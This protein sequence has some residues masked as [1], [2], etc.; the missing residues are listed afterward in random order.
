MAKSKMQ[1]EIEAKIG[2]AQKDISNLK[3]NVK[4][5][6]KASQVTTKKVGFFKRSINELSDSMKV[7]STI[8]IIGIVTGLVNA[9]KS[10]F[11]F[12]KELTKTTKLVSDLTGKS[13]EDL[14]SFT[15]QIQATSDTF[16]LEFKEVLMATNTLSKEMGESF[17]VS[18]K[19]IQNGLLNGA[20]AS[21]ELLS[22]ISEYSTQAKRAGLNTAE[23]IKVLDVQTEKGVFSDKGIDTI[24]EATIRLG[25]MPEATK[26]AI[27]SIGL[28]SKKMQEDIESGSVTFFQATQQISRKLSEL[29][30]QSSKVGEV[31]ANVFGGAGE[32]AQSFVMALGDINLANANQVKELTAIDL[33]K[34]QDLENQTRINELMSSF[35]GE[36][37]TGFSQ[38]IT[39][40][41][42]IS[43]DLI[44]GMIKGVKDLVTWFEDLTDNSKF[45]RMTISS[46]SSVF[47]VLWETAKSSIGIMSTSFKSLGSLIEGVFTLDTDKIKEAYTNVAKAIKDTVIDGMKSLNEEQKALE[48]EFSITNEEARKQRLAERFEAEKTAEK[49]QLDSIQTIKLNALNLSNQKILEATKKLNAQRLKIVKN[50][51][52]KLVKTKD[53]AEKTIKGNTV[54]NQLSTLKFQ[55]GAGKQALGVFK[56]EAMGGLIKSIMSSVPFPLNVIMSGLA[57]AT[58]NTLFDKIPAF[59]DGA[60]NGFVSGN[61]FTGDRVLT[62]V[63][64]GEAILNREQQ[65]NFLDL[66]T[67]RSKGSNN[68]SY[69]ID[70]LANKIEHLTDEI[71]FK[72]QNLDITLSNEIQASDFVT[73]VDEGNRDLNRLA[74]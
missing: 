3:D 73:V 46:I 67:G 28:S 62:R 14:K 72:E 59:E 44:V 36:N 18:L 15:S 64:S 13:G 22:N 45:L 41:T 9:G 51:E 71:V 39:D 40:L 16:E 25:E 61:S 38:M 74:N 33:M 42:T 58:V 47:N 23:F 6:G 50:S 54:A 52:S 53:N 70:N 31:L 56:G 4:N 55:E 17:E 34:K 7:L 63:N 10:L 66:A 30:S 69:A 35:F 2:N 65:K 1:I 32:D 8:G 57:G 29:P 27:D 68:S 43:L 19:Q 21:G 5:V 12:N 24:K 26:K 11:N 60:E 48:S 20:N 37:N 49:Q